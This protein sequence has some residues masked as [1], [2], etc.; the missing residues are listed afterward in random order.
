MERRPARRSRPWVLILNADAWLV[1]DALER[2]VAVGDAHPDVAVVGPRLLN[3]DGS[4]QRSVRASPPAGGSPPN[5]STSASSPR[6]R[7]SLNAFYAGGFDH[8]SE[9]EAEFVMGSC[10]LV[11]RAAIDEVAPSTR[12]LPVQRRGRLVLPLRTGRLE[13]AVH[14]G[15]RQCVHV[16]GAS[17]GG[18]LYRENIRGYFRF[19]AK[20]RGREASGCGGCC[21]CRS[22]SAGGSCADSVARCTATRRAG[23]PP[24]MS[25][26]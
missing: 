8:E 20:H 11:R 10:M 1:D 14:A 23:S 13:D 22:R 7:N 24:A 12:L 5:I 18:R 6:A 15:A 4:L 16:G 21:A 9:R 17:H 2:L 25:R 19:F 26:P 3:P